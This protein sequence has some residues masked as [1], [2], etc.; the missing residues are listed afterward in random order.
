MVRTLDS[1]VA[2]YQRMESNESN[3]QYIGCSGSGLISFYKAIGISIPVTADLSESLVNA[4]QYQVRKILPQSLVAVCL[5][6]LKSFLGFIYKSRLS[7]HDLSIMIKPDMDEAIKND[8]N[9][10]VDAPKLVS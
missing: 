6:D 8:F 4:Y 9:G 5:I 3:A 7:L 2:E 1:L 10:W